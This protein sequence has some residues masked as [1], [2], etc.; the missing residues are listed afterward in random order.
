MTNY[1]PQAKFFIELNEDR[2]VVATHFSPIGR[3]SSL[4]A[5]A[6]EIDHTRYETITN[7]MSDK[8]YDV[9]YGKTGQVTLLENLEKVRT[10]A[11][12]TIAG[13]KRKSRQTNSFTV[14]N[15]H[16]SLY[17][18]D[19]ILLLMSIVTDT[20]LDLEDSVTAELVDVSPEDACEALKTY[21]ND[22]N[23]QNSKYNRALR[24]IK[25]CDE[26]DDIKRSLMSVGLTL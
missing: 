18:K 3:P 15:K 24:K 26:T 14:N 1:S 4:N 16:M 22:I 7:A 17:N 5:N 2:H 6:I 19:I 20:S 12:E 23:R 10:K 11:V 13:A 21:L 8:I 9:Y 25:S